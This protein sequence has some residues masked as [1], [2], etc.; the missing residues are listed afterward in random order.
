MVG[1]LK[2]HMKKYKKIRIENE[3]NGQFCVIVDNKVIASGLNL[4]EIAKK[5][6]EYLNE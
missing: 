5:I 4:K 3:S 2:Q 6:E 1:R